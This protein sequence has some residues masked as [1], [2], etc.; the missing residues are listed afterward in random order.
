MQ[1]SQTVTIKE[2]RDNLAQIIEEVAIAGKQVEITK[3]GKK[4]AVLVPFGI[5]Q[6]SIRK[7]AQINF[8]KLPGVGMWKDREDMKDSAKWVENLR[9]GEE[10]RFP[11]LFND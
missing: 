6:K 10:R 9:R 3:F 8:A 4:K 11:K 7:R 1:V 5:A 2:L